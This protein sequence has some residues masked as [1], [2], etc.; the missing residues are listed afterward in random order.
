MS[1]IRHA[2][3]LQEKEAA[4]NASILLQEVDMEKEREEVKKQAAARKREKKKK[5]KKNKLVGKDDG[6]KMAG[7]EEEGE[8][9]D[10]GMVIEKPESV[11]SAKSL[12][13]G[14]GRWGWKQDHPLGSNCY[15]WNNVTDTVNSISDNWNDNLQSF[16]QE[17][18]EASVLVFY[19]DGTSVPVSQS[20]SLRGLDVGFILPLPKKLPYM[21]SNDEYNDEY[22]CR[23][24]FVGF[25]FWPKLSFQYR[26]SSS[27]DRY[28]T[29]VV[30]VKLKSSQKRT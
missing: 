29:V 10:E 11:K 1:V 16:N 21:A 8:D 17:K 3:D 14:Q 20:S 24:F 19:A 22:L 9:D 27:L 13:N 4:K 2:K 7:K 18:N 28:H 12:K 23:D 30:I 26:T 6:D 15:R 25:I 5:K